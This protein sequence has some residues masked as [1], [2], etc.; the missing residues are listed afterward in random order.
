[1]AYLSKSDYKIAHDCHT[2]LFYKKKEYPSTNDSNEYLQFLAQGGYMVGKLATLYYPDGIEITTGRDH[3][4]AVELTANYLKEENVTLFESSILS[5]GKLIRIDILK[6]ENKTLHLIEVKSKSYDP[7]DDLDNN[8]YEDYLFDVGF[9]YVVLK[10]KFP[11][12]KIIPY[13]FMPD[14]SKVTSIEGLAFLFNI[15]ENKTDSKFRSY[16]ITVPAERIQDLIKDNILTLINVEEYVVKLLP[17]IE[18]EVKV[19]LP[20]LKD[21]IKK[22]DVPLSKKCFKCEYSITE[23]ENKLS[24]FDECWKEMPKPEF[25]LKDLTRV[26]F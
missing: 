3:S 17:A 1:M 15:K 4:L 16:D 9:Q 19:L 5:N 26:A 13:L 7:E 22:I 8:D 24:G 6:K 12:Y 25:H 23:D 2:K 11:E 14:K 21:E 20:S 10:E 18:Q